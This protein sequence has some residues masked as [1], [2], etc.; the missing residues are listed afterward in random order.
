LR[1]E[2]RGKSPAKERPRRGLIHCNQEDP[3]LSLSAH[4]DVWAETPSPSKE[5]P[6]SASQS[7]S[8]QAGR[9]KLTRSDRGIS[10]YW[11]TG[12][13]PPSI[14]RKKA[15]RE[16]QGAVW[17]V[18]D[19]V[20]SSPFTEEIERAE[21][22]EKF[23]APHFE[24]YNSRTD[25]VAHIGHYQQRMALCRYN[26]PLMCRLF[27]SSL[28]EVMLRWFNQLEQGTVGSWSQMAEAFVGRFIT[29]SRRPKVMDTLMMMKLGDNES[30]KDYSARFWEPYNNIDGCGEDMVVRTFKLGLP[31]STGLRQSLTKRPPLI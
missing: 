3:A 14:P 22:P 18:L 19:L 31:P 20:S 13:L 12:I 25:P 28:G 26:D 6:H 7:K 17:K 9:K 29:N 11:D 10:G 30:I 15:R 8:V 27:P 16:E 2:A 24:V 23:T 1:K 4:T 21:L 5:I